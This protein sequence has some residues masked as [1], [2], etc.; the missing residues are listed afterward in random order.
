MAIDRDGPKKFQSD[1][2]SETIS[3]LFENKVI[4]ITKSS[5]AYVTLNVVF[6]HIA[7]FREH[8]FSYCIAAM[9]V[10]L[11][12]P[13]IY[14]KTSQL[15]YL[16]DDKNLTGD[17]NF[18]KLQGFFVKKNAYDNYAINSRVSS[19]IIQIQRVSVEIIFFQHTPKCKPPQL[20]LDQHVQQ[21]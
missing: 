14:S 3:R 16:T 8:S 6:N 17:V 20:S 9:R 10:F 15:S 5:F 12:F 11:I 7:T 4:Q 18:T 2:P 19:E 21:N 13:L 1:P